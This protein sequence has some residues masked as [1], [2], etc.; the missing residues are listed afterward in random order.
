MN[1]ERL[2]PLTS[3][4]LVACVKREIALRERVYP[5]WI[6]A[7][8]MTQEKANH[9][10]RCMRAVLNIVEEYFDAQITE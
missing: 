5:K 6:S 4:E 7:G 2:F 8:R 3:D 10:I 1:Q 9:E